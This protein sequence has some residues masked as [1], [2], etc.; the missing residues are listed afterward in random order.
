M[1]LMIFDMWFKTSKMAILD[2]QFSYLV[3]TIF[4]MD[5]AWYFSNSAMNGI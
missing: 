4:L 1:Q 3:A 2:R 5:F